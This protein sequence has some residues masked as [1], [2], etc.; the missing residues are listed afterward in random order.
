MSAL[1]PRSGW[2]HARP[3]VSQDLPGRVRPLADELS[4]HPG[5]R[6]PELDTAD[7]GVHRRQAA[8]PTIAGQPRRTGGRRSRTGRR[9][10]AH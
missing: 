6:Q 5:L 2:G 3:A 10:G 7:A 9:D 1:P 4:L 8:V